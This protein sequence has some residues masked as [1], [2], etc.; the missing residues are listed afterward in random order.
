MPVLHEIKNDRIGDVLLTGVFDGHAGTAASKTATGILPSLFTTELLAAPSDAGESAIREALENAWET[1]CDTY[2]KGCDKNGE[3]VADYD[4]REGI[5][6]AETGSTDLVAG[7]TATV[8][9]ISMNPQGAKELTVLNCGDSRTLLIGEPMLPDSGSSVIVFETRDHSPDDEEEKIRLEKGKASGLDYSLPVCPMTSG[10]YIVVGDY[11]Y[12]VVRSLE[13]SFVTS[14]GIVSDPDIA[15]LN[16][17]GVF[18]DARPGALVLACD[19]LFEVM[20]NEEVGREVVRMRREEYKAGDI[21]KNLCGQ[22]LKKGSYD[23]VSVVV[24]YLDAV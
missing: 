24:V 1:T 11:Q 18:T 10:S 4:P 7:T 23:N 13:G 6:F 16:L 8:A 20:S 9:A 22:A 19:G 15:S 21:A 5:L 3:C 14:K 17:A 12:A 2:R